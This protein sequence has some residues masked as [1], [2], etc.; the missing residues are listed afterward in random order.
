MIK[1]QLP[2]GKY[3]V[4]KVI[5]YKEF[6]L[7]I[8]IIISFVWIVITYFALVTRSSTQW[9][10]MRQAWKELEA[11]EL[12]VSNIVFESVQKEQTLRK[13]IDVDIAR[14]WRIN[15]KKWVSVHTE[16]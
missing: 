9:F 1:Y 3:I 2:T 16:L 14:D 13:N 7:W 15:D 4:E 8:I 6:L 11:K 12:D 10:F 5:D